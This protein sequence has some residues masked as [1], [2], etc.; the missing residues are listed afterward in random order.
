V[1]VLQLGLAGL[2]GVCL[3]LLSCTISKATPTLVCALLALC[4]QVTWQR[5]QPH[6]TVATCFEL[7]AQ[8]G[9]LFLVTWLLVCT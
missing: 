2:W 7:A 5:W 1:A 6:H 9:E 4:M 3:S 8:L